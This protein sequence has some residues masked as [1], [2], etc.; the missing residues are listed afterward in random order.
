ML[1]EAKATQQKSF[2]VRQLYY[3]FRTWGDRLNQNKLIRP[4]FL[5]IDNDRFSIVE[6]RFDDVNLYSSIELVKHATYQL[7]ESALSK[8]ELEGYLSQPLEKIRRDVPFP[9]ADSINR[10][11]SLLI[12]IDL[13]DGEIHKEDVATQQ[14]FVDR[15]TDYYTN[16]AQYLGLVESS[17]RDKEILVLTTLGYKVVEN[18]VISQSKVMAAR[19][20]RDPIIRSVFLEMKSKGYEFSSN[21][22]RQFAENAM[23]AN[24]I[25]L[26]D[27]T[28]SRRA[29]TIC[30]WCRWLEDHLF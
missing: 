7:T 12:S 26:A 27:S 28:I 3:P 24:G 11:I 14:V 18:G 23:I 10:I 19:L 16:A 22:I 6:Y 29:Q 17:K 13:N 9:Q 8:S 4:M 25:E 20:L 21:G 5:M 15:Q 1:V 2:L 30:S